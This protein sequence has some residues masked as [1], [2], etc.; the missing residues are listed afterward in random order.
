MSL[1][2]TSARRRGGVGQENSFLGEHHPVR[3]YQRKL[4]RYF[5]GV[6]YTPP[7]LRRGKRANATFSNP[8]RLNPSASVRSQRFSPAILTQYGIPL[9]AGDAGL[10]L[11][12]PIDVQSYPIRLV[13]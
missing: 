12:R 3:S 13:N 2:N 9:R 7:P 8:P 6:A 11:H 10:A 1:S 5:L 4:S